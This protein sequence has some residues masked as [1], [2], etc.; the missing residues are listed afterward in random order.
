MSYYIKP[1]D[2]IFLNLSGGTVTGGTIFTAGLSANTFYSGSTELGNLIQSMIVD[3]VYTAITAADIYLPISGG[4]GGPYVFTGG[5]T[6]QTLSIETKVEPKTDNTASVGTPIRRFRS[7]HTV[8]GVAV[9][10]TASTRI[11]LGNN[12]GRELTEYNI[13]LTGD[14]I[15]AG[16]WT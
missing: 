5:T 3:Y 13:I 6:A 11:R 14:T 7:L 1:L 15:D 10:F 12:P 4:T 8:N 2:R 16:Q 9:E